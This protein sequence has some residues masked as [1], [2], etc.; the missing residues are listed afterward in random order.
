MT[1]STTVKK[2]TRSMTDAIYRNFGKVCSG[3]LILGNKR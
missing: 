1:L 3:V 2:E